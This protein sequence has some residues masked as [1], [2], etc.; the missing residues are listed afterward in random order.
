V[1]EIKMSSL[2]PRQVAVDLL[3]QFDGDTKAANE[4]FMQEAQ[5]K[6]SDGRAPNEGFNIVSQ[7][8]AEI[9]PLQD[10]V[11]KMATG[12][13][14]TKNDIFDNLISDYVRRM[15]EL[16]GEVYEFEMPEK[17]LSV[18][19]ELFQYEQAL[20]QLQS[21]LPH[22]DKDDREDAMWNVNML[23]SKIMELKSGG[24]MT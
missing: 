12:K 5:S 21:K 11:D 19:E 17:E 8:L 10:G 13:R 24:M 9:A 2:D 7:I 3:M 15:N 16:V 4:N 23:S 1:E 18:E 6:F 22:V 20:I 14:I